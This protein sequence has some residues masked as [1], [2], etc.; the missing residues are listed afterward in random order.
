MWICRKCNVKHGDGAASCISCGGRKEDVGA[1]IELAESSLQRIKKHSKVKVNS[2]FAILAILIIPVLVYLR[3]SEELKKEDQQLKRSELER[4][5]IRVNAVLD[6]GERKAEVQEIAEGECQKIDYGKTLILDSLQVAMKFFSP[7]ERVEFSSFLEKSHNKTLLDMD[8][9]KME[10]LVAEKS[11]QMSDEENKKIKMLVKLVKSRPANL[12]KEQRAPL[13]QEI[14]DLYA[15]KTL[16]KGETDFSRILQGMG[17]E[18][19]IGITLGRLVGKYLS[20]SE[21]HEFLSLEKQLPN[22][23]ENEKKRI[24]ALLQKIQ[25]KCSQDEKLIVDVYQ[26]YLNG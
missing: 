22:L 4:A 11:P 25:G 21:S 10:I 16:E 5:I 12:S 23:T 19:K 14:E 13:L 26:S 9:K 1:V 18:E 2:L 8:I 20:E 24:K 3:F 6:E 15:G 17:F 7:E